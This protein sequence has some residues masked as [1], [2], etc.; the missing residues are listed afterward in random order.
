LARHAGLTEIVDLT[1]AVVVE[2]VARLRDRSGRR[3][4]NLLVAIARELARA[5]NTE[6]PRHASLTEVVDLA[7]AIVIDAVTRLGRRY[8]AR[9]THL[10]VAATSERAGAASALLARHAGLT[11]IVD[12]TVAV[13][14]EPIA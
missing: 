5:A 6:K 9:V 13:V 11:E 8:R 7:I 2:P 1:V 4:A 10:L 14:V 3:I 12:L